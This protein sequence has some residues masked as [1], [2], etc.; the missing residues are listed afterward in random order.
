MKCVI[1]GKPVDKH[2]TP[3]GRVYWTNGYKADPVKDG[4]CCSICN[5]TIVLP[6]AQ[7]KS[8]D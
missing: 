2:F 3:N 4:R 5:N 7:L 8:M 1:C 6:A